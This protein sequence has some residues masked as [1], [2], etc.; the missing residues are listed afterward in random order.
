MNLGKLLKQY[1]KSF[2]FTLRDVENLSSYKISN[3]YLC[4]IEK[5][6]IKSPSFE[7]L[8]VLA[9]IY[10][11]N[12][13][14]FTTYLKYDKKHKKKVKKK[15]LKMRLTKTGLGIEEA[16]CMSNLIDCWNTFIAMERTHPDE[17]N[18]FK[19]GIHKLESILALRVVRRL[20][21]EGWFSLK[22]N[23]KQNK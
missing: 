12:I 14:H 5:G 10:N 9:D 18:D 3:S 2:S 4:Q 6:L 8:Q 1:R 16:K 23:K 7:K 20:Y 19:E 17:L 22:N 11:V 21:P 15:L 13:N